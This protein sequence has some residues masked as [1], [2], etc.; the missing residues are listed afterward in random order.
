MDSHP[1]T[2]QWIAARLAALT[3]SWEPD[4]VRARALLRPARSPRRPRTVYALA[5][6]TAALVVAF[7][8]PSG[9]ALA[10]DLWY[11]FYAS[12]IAV[13]RLDLSHNPLETSIRSRDVGVEVDSVERAAAVAGF[14]PYLP[15]AAGL[16]ETPVINVIGRLELTQTVRAETL[17]AALAAVGASDLEVPAEWDGTRLRA[18]IGPIVSARYLDVVP[19]G[20]ERD[21]EILQMPAVKLEMPADFPL[22]RLAE[23]VFRSA[24]SGWWEARRLAEEYATSPA[25][26]FDVPA[27]AQVTV[28]EIAMPRGKGLLVEYRDDEADAGAARYLVLIGRPWRL[29]GVFAPDRE[30]ALRAAEALP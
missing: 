11:R 4:P 26:L 22:A 25:W 12:R 1:E 2:P 6:A 28:E 18:E 21:L 20:R 30:L 24:G 29:Y 27:N 17:R 7:A 10:Q 19:G 15:K 16:P 14:T 23:V 8:N 9:R 13:V 3:P 5:A